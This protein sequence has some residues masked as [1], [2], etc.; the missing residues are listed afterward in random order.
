[1][2]KARRSAGLVASG[3]MLL[4]ITAVFGAPPPSVPQM[5]GF[6]PKQEGVAYSTPTDKDYDGCKVEAIKGQGKGAG[7]QLRDAKG[8]LVRRYFDSRYD[9]KAK[10]GID[11]WSYY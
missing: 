10:S 3:V 1:M 7:W 11:T 2:A 8:Q 5:L 9:G 4:T 6:R